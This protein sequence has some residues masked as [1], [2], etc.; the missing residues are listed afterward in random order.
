MTQRPVNVA[1]IGAG[2]AGIFTADAL[3]QQAVP[4]RVDLFEK[5]PTPFGLVRYGVAPDSPQSS[6]LV[7]SLHAILARRDIRLVA[8]IDVGT[9]ITLE[10]LRQAYDAVVVSTGASVDAP[11]HI[12]GI[13]LSGSFGASEFVAWYNAHPDA[14]A[15]WDFD[16]EHVAVF[17]AGNVAVDV[18]RILAKGADDL[19]HTEVPDHVYAGLRAS[20]VTDVHLFARRGPAEAAFSVAELRE[21]DGLSDVDLIVDPADLIIDR[22]SEHLMA[23]FRQRRMVVETLR[24][25]AARDRSSLTAARR[26]HLHFMQAPIRVHGG[27]RVQGIT[28][29]RT[30]HLVNGTVEGTGSFRH[31]AVGQVYRAIGYASVP[32]AGVPFSRSERRVP[33]LLGRVLDLDG[34]IIHAL[35][36]AGWA[37]R[38]P[39]GLVGFSRSDAFQTVSQIVSDFEAPLLEG[40]DDDPLPGLLNECGVQAV[41]WD[42]WLRV[43]QHER[44]AGAQSGRPRV[45]LADPQRLS[46]VAHGRTLLRSQPLC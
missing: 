39:V 6:T 14:R 33:N 2:P 40:P 9:D 42:G 18:S 3:L 37:K 34:G 7:E 12:P 31:Y 4:T 24:E 38:G 20:R 29:E 8:G 28:V 16:S 13:G 46:D 36:V 41:D 45:K 15:R 22:S 30:R 21:L 5:L 43:D 1:V 17:G 25:W 26:V 11:L 27:E 23:A 32:I 35:Y 44:A 19:R 10:R